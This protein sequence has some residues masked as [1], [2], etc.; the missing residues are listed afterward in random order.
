MKAALPVGPTKSAGRW[1]AS[2]TALAVERAACH[3]QLHYAMVQAVRQ[4][5][6]AVVQEGSSRAF[7]LAALFSS[8]AACYLVHLSPPPPTW[9]ANG[10][11]V[12]LPRGRPANDVGSGGSV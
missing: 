3:K 8:L 6:L 4:Q 12:A 11:A 9:Q 7:F 1:S 10:Q 5:M 2:S